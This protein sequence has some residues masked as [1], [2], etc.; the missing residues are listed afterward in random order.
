MAKVHR[1]VGSEAASVMSN[2]TAGRL[3]SETQKGPLTMGALGMRPLLLCPGLAFQ[4]G[5]GRWA[6]ARGARGLRLQE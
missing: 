6:S 5:Q 2:F 3:G 4:K 1:E